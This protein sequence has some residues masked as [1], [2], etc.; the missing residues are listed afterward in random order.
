MSE[1][2]DKKS[3]SRELDDKVLKRRAYQREYYKKRYH[4]NI[5]ESRRKS[6]EQARKWRKENPEKEA[7][8]Q[9][10]YNAKIAGLAPQNPTA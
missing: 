9:A 5:E 3:T 6:R 1:T 4:D 10:R 7:L 8:I 2:T